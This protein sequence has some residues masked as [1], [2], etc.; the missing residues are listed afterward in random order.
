MEYLSKSDGLI[1]SLYKDFPD[2]IKDGY[3]RVFL[4]YSLLTSKD[5]YQN[6]GNQI[7]DY[8]KHNPDYNQ[9]TTIFDLQFSTNKY[10]LLEEILHN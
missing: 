4:K 6:N 9:M 5:E 7:A 1:D 8:L 3:K 2:K 10:M